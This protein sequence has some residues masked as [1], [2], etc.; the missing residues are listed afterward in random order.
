QDAIV[1]AM[2]HTT[3]G[4]RGIVVVKDDKDEIMHSFNAL[5]KGDRVLFVDAQTGRQALGPADPQVVLFVATTDGVP[6]PRPAPREKVVAK[7]TGEQAPHAG[8]RP[9]TG[10][11]ES[12]ADA[13][14]SEAGPQSAGPSTTVEDPAGANDRFDPGRQLTESRRPYADT[15]TLL[16]GHVLV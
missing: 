4:S 13:D 8:T 15:G 6:D 5:K 16:D 12:T 10:P 1:E 9:G 2:R 3:H 11:G 14:M 7:P